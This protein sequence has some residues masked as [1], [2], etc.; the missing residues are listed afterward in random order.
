MSFWTP[1]RR[2]FLKTTALATGA[3]LAAPYVKTAHS[4]GK[5]SL[6]LWDHW[7]PGANDVL[8][9]LADDW[10]KQNNVEVTIDFITSVG[11][12]D[13]VTAA[14]ESRAKTG[15]DVLSHRTWQVAVYQNELEPMDDVV[16]E[17]EK[18]Y[19]PYT[20][21]ASYLARF[22]NS[23]RGI[24]APTGSHTYPMVSRLDLWKQDAGVDLKA[25]FP[26][27]PRDQAKI[28]KEWTYANFLGHAKK[29]HAAGHEFGNPIGQTSD[30]Q[31][32]LGPLFLAFGSQPMNADGDITI[33]SDETRAA[34]D[35]MQQLTQ[36][37]PEDVYAWD[38]AGNNRWIISGRG[39]SIQNPPSAWA[40]AVRDAPDVGSQIWHHDVPSGPKGRYR[41]SLPFFWAI[42][43]FAPNKSAAKELILYLAAKE[44]FDKLIKA[45]RGY[46]LP[47]QPSFYDD[48]VW[49][50][51]GPPPGT[52]YNYPLR[53]DEKLIVAGYPA[54]PTVAARIYNEGLI[55]VMVA[56][57]TQG[58]ESVDDA[59]AWAA[60]ELEGYQ[61]G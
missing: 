11:D 24:V 49:E 4:A 22:D 53:G 58:G 15:H 9:Q 2:K 28:D 16:G 23:W 43:N 12:K 8:K 40:V 60:D 36:Y 7:V 17:M 59:I 3:T 44:Q 30:S 32:W 27:G 35:Y 25:L 26:A 41:G 14:A 46:D 37:M 18:K 29:L 47:L 34:L 1:N 57:V 31:D 10:G 5:V 45:A 21:T 13:L 33:D 52:E 61:R 55:P 39:S 42:W 20:D 38:D 6:G 54:E 56:K 50:N 51:E 48:P 19:G